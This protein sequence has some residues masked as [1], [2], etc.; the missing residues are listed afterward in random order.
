MPGPPR[1]PTNV[2]IAEGLRGHRPLNENEPEPIP[3]MPERPTGLSAW[4]R[5]LWDVCVNEL[6][7]LNL[8]TIADHGAFEAA[9]LGADTARVADQKVRKLLAKINRDKA[10]QEDYYR[11]SIMNSVSKKGWQQYKAFCTEFGMTPASRT[12]LSSDPT[13]SAAGAVRTA[14]KKIDAIEQA[15]IGTLPN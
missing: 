12:R 3:G 2:R 8:L 6:D 1:K 5:N 13:P 10:E 15:V 11:L 7:R 9:V 4:G 14:G